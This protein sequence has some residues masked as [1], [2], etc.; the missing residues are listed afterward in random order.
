VI[1]TFSTNHDTCAAQMTSSKSGAVSSHMGERD[2]PK[3]LLPKNI[4]HMMKSHGL[5][6]VVTWYGGNGV[7]ARGLRPTV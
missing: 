3:F 5:D 2:W 1:R 7:E 6:E 4:E